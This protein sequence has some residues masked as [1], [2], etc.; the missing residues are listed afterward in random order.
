MRNMINRS[1]ESLDALLMLYRDSTAVPEASA[2]FMPKLWEAIEGRRS[3][4]LRLKRVSQVFVGSAAVI[5]LCLGGFMV[6]PRSPG[7][8]HPA[9]YVDELAAA[10]PTENLAAQ[11]IVKLENPEV[12]Q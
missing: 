10:H 11:G 7:A 2:H 12:S 6:S 3:F 8:L 5:C 1:D 4:T 9:T